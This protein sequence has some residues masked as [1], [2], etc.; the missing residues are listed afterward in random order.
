MTIKESGLV[1]AF[2]ITVSL[3]AVFLAAPAFAYLVY[4]Q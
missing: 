2:K 4:M 1:D 3:T